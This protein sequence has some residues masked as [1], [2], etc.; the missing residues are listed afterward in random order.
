MSSLLRPVSITNADCTVRANHIVGV[1]ESGNEVTEDGVCATVVYEPAGG[2][3]S[4]SSAG[5][6]KAI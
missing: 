5:W 2:T 1:D 3:M 4:N 6:S